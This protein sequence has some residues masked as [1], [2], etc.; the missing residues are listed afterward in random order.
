MPLLAVLAAA[1]VLLIGA[2]AAQAY[3]FGEPGVRAAGPEVRLFDWTTQKCNNDDIPDQSTKAFR[4]VNGQVVMINSHHTTRRWAGPSLASVT[5]SCTIMMG[6]GKNGDPSMFD[7]REWLGTTW[8]SDGRTVHG[9]IHSEYQGYNQAPGYCIEEGESFADKQKCWYN[10]LT[11]TKSTNNGA[12]FSH[13]PPPAHFVAGPAYPYAAG[14]GP[15][16][17]FQPSNIVRGKDGYL[18]LLAHVQDYGAQPFGS[19]LMRTNNIDDPTSWR[20]WDGSGFNRRSVD[21]Y[22]T[23]I[24]D[25]GQHTCVPVSPHVGTISESLGWSTYLKKWV[26]VG[27]WAGSTQ[28][29]GFY[30]FTSDDLVNWS[31]AKLL[32]NGELPWTYNCGD[33]PEQIRDPSVLDN[34]STSRNFDTIGQRPFLYFTRFNMSGCSTSLDRDLI[35]IPIEFSNQQPGGPAATLAASTQAPHTGESVTFD[36]SGSSDADGSITAYKWDLDGDGLYERDTGT[37]PVTSRVYAAPD[38]VTVTVRVCDDDGKGTDET[39]IVDVSGNEIAPQPPNDGPPSA[40]CPRPSGGGGGGGTG[41]PPPGDPPP[42]DPPP[43]DPPPGDPPGGNPAGG[44]APQGSGGQ[45]GGFSAGTAAPASPAASVQVSQPPMGTFRLVG[46]PRSRRNG[47]LLL[48]VHVPAAGRLTVRGRGARKPIRRARRNAA[49]PGTLRITVR[50]SKAG[51]RLLRRKRRAKVRAVLV[52][53]PVGGARQR[54]TR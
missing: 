48:R 47:S 54:S 23:N 16:G 37:S 15:I 46:K 26:L 4:D 41:D 30:Y 49:K 51:K 20:L 14:I 1:V 42:G 38:K 2:P 29:S 13:A 32:M 36:A 9:L 33:G 22:R 25:P 5:H 19:C 24:T 28:G 53:R 27:S 44:G 21:P 40:T 17:Y 18:Y 7:D 35:R 10:T 34:D 31:P 50:L 11:L 8:T 12:T 3:T 52:F 39:T 45:G 43:D 6:S